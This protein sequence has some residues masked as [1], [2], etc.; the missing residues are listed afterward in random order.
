MP[1]AAMQRQIMS[2]LAKAFD[3]RG[4]FASPLGITAVDA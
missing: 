3:P 2:Q 4:V 1:I